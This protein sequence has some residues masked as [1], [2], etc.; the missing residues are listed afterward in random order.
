MREHQPLH[1]LQP[2]LVC[3]TDLVETAMD[4]H[5][6]PDW[7]KTYQETSRNELALWRERI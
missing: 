1:E 2:T 6:K 3:E 7:L 4:G 5:D